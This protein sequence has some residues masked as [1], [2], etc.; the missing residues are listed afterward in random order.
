MACKRLP[1]PLVTHC[2][3]PAGLLPHLRV[4]DDLFDRRVFDEA[5]ALYPR[6]RFHD[7]HPDSWQIHQTEWQTDNDFSQGE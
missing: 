5:I 6:N 3:V 4:A 2:D 7:R 1:C